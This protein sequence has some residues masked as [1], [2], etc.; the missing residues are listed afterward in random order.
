MDSSTLTNETT[1]LAQDISTATDD[2]N[3]LELAV[4]VDRD[5]IALVV[6][7]A[8][9]TLDLADDIGQRIERVNVSCVC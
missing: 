8:S 5:A 7:T 1:A 4:D 2:V 3:E 6:D 9:E